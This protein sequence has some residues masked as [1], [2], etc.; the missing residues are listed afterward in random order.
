MIYAIVAVDSK[1]GVATEKGIPWKIP[2]DQAYFREKTRGCPIVMGYGMYKEMK[3]PLPD[4]RNIVIVHP[5]TTVT[6][7]FEAIEDIDSLLDAYQHTDEVLWVVGGARVYQKLLPRIQKL[8][9]TQIQADFNC[10]KFFPEFE[11]SFELAHQSVAQREGDV[12][13][14]YEIWDSQS[15]LK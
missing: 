7:G 4:R 8:Y 15:S 10:T 9:I 6:E 11:G 2:A 5:G 14:C 3:L 1:R 12:M 13:F